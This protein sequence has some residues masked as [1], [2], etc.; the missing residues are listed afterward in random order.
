[1]ALWQ[2]A[3]RTAP[4][5]HRC[6]WSEMRIIY[7]PWR[8]F[9]AVSHVMLLRQGGAWSSEA[10]RGEFNSGSTWSWG[11]PPGP[12][13]RPSAPLLT[14]A[15]GGARLLWLIPGQR[16]DGGACWRTSPR[17]HQDSRIR[18]EA[19][20]R[21]CGLAA[22]SFELCACSL[23]FWPW[24]CWRWCCWRCLRSLSALVLPSTRI[25]AQVRRNS[26]SNYRSVR[27]YFITRV[28]GS[29]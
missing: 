7:N 14:S 5:L 1:M 11:P 8:Y 10:R 12:G 16:R 29:I 4:L 22:P 3:P 28:F 15:G 23:R 13:L 18:D 9:A 6:L 17:T 21:D 27:R 25:S 24:R 19:A 20:D 26:T 2:S